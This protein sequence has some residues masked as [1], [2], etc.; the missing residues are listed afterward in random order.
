MAIRR[1]PSTGDAPRS[2]GVPESLIAGG[3]GDSAGFPWEGRTFDHHDTE[4]SD[5]DGET[6]PQYAHAVAAIRAAVVAGDA[7]GLSDAVTAVLLALGEVRVL[8]PLVTEAGDLGVTP[9]GAVVEKTQEL[10]IVTV[11]APDGRTAMPVFTSVAALRRWNADAR[12]IPVPGP[13]AALAVAQEETDLLIVD[14]GSPETEF[15]VRRT[16]LQA[17][18]TTTPY[19]VPWADET[20]RDAFSASVAIDHRICSIDI[21]PGDPEH[22]LQ[23]AEVDVVVVLQH[24]LQREELTEVL[25]ALQQFWATNEVIADRVDSM[26]VLPRSAA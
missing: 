2:T 12:P 7:V 13:Q 15:A 26:R 14:P 5:D 11:F 4:F 8:V 25:Q 9:S 10:S 17:L 24:G 6:P 3:A 22:R 18:A 16:Q 23:A 19:L 21:R 20:V 1:L